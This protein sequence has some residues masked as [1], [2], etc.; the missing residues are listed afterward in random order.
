MW[1]RRSRGLE[2]ARLPLEGRVHVSVDEKP[3]SRVPQPRAKSPPFYTHQRINI[4]K[5]LNSAMLPE[6]R[7]ELIMFAY[8]LSD[9]ARETPGERL[10]LTKLAERQVAHAC[11]S[12]MGETLSLVIAAAG[13]SDACFR[14]GSIRPGISLC[15][16][17][18]WLGRLPVLMLIIRD[19]PFTRVSRRLDTHERASILPLDA[20]GAHLE[21]YG[22]TSVVSIIQGRLGSVP[23]NNKS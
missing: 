14:P 21:D 23:R 7:S 20:T 17:V 12:S 16:L 6:F 1:F 13:P 22:L 10:P 15:A 4:Q 19:W 8:V 5:Y 3:R 9:W 11:L 2:P 18:R